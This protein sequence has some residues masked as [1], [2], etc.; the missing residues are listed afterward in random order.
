MRSFRK[1]F[2]RLLLIVLGLAL[3]PLL[4]R[5]FWV[6]PLATRMAREKAG[7]NIRIGS[8]R[9]GILR[10]TFDVRG[11]SLDNP[12]DSQEPE[13]FRVDRM[14]IAADWTGLFGRELHIRD[15]RMELPH[16]TLIRDA[17]GKTNF[18]RI[19]EALKR[20]DLTRPKPDAKPG[21]PEKSPKQPASGRKSRPY[22][23][24]QL[25]VR[26]GDVRLLSTAPDGTVTTNVYPLRVDQTFTDVTDLQ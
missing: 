26:I 5:D 23:I 4:L 8:M 7:L 2:L 15:I 12:P 6:P 13:A 10:P 18:E 11:M 3:L 16:L 17:E 1:Y 24:D 25:T 22:R 20:P 21:S 9:T 14:R 19:G